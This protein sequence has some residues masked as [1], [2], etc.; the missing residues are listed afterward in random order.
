MLLNNGGT[1]SLFSMCHVWLGSRVGSLIRVMIPGAVLAD[2]RTTTQVCDPRFLVAAVWEADFRQLG[3]VLGENDQT[4]VWLS[5]LTGAAGYESSVVLL[6]AVDHAEVIAVG[7][8]CGAFIKDG[9]FLGEAPAF[10]LLL[11]L[12]YFLRQQIIINEGKKHSFLLTEF[13]LTTL[14]EASC[15]SNCCVSSLMVLR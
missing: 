9:C 6:W 12:S 13:C 7:P 8:C 10:F 11:Q 14:W 1:K 4:A 2:G 3:S 15:C 5:S